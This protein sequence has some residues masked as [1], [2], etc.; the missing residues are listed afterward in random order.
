M[1]PRALLLW[2]CLATPAAA[3]DVRYGVGVRTDART[4]TPL[5]GD[6]GTVVTGDLELTPRADLSIGVDASTFSALYSPTL[7]WREPQT[8]GRFLPLHRVRLAFQTV[9]PRTT[10]LISQDAAYGL[11]DVGFLRQPDGSLPGAVGELQT[12]GALPYVRSA[13]MVNLETQ[14]DRFSLGL[15]AGYLLS[16]ST[17]QNDALPFQYGPTASARAR[18]AV[19]RTDGLTTMAQ[20]S[21]ARFVT[22]QE[23]LIA[24]L[25]EIWDRQV[26][27][28]VTFNAGV[29]VALTREQI[30]AQNG[31]PG[32]YAELLPIA[33]AS[34]SWRDVVANNPL[35]F[36]T[37]A[38]MA[39][40][41]DRFTA[42]VY[43][44]VELR[45]QGEWIPARNWVVTAGT[46][47]ALAVPVSL[48]LSKPEAASSLDRNG[49]N[50]AGDRLLFGEGAV[51]WTAKTWLLF[52]ASAR[53]LWTEQPRLNQPGMVQAVGTLSVTVQQ[54]DSLAW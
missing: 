15:S 44:R 42:N 25:S 32:T 22:G 23:Q 36:T 37:S 31:L 48:S 47:G 24:Q 2:A 41:A 5:P 28:T 21:A 46:G 7:V 35:R 4:R 19:S 30:T 16:G 50:Q 26:S 33:L 34:L 51:G 53:V 27:R 18:V 43:E 29:G 8:G 17:E 49:M 54:Q 10:F 1:K 9:W 40:F 14:A 3:A 13:T 45:L 20:V 52:Q 11:A 39:P 38:R 6:R 12:I